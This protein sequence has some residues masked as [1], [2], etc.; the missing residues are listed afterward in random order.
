MLPK[1]H[2][3]IGFL[4]SLVL[5]SI[6][7]EITL[8]NTGIIFLSSILIDVDHYL[9]FVFKK[10]NLSLKKAYFYFIEKKKKL[11]KMSLKEKRKNYNGF[12]FL[13]GLEFLLLV[14]FLGYFISEIFYFILIGLM[15]HFFLDYSE[16]IIDKKRIDK[17]SVI[18]DFIK[19]KKL[20]FLE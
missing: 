17:I 7:P 5:Y 2:I 4:F 9:Y 20:K 12:Y 3:L 11:E 1:Y 14:F 15:L 10:R 6:F 19:F 13:H 8:L 16:M 18:Y